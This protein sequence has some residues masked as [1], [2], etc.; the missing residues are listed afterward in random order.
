[1]KVLLI[2]PPGSDM[3]LNVGLGYLAASLQETGNEV[4]VLDLNNQ[5]TAGYW[6]AAIYRPSPQELRNI[7][8][9][10]IQRRFQPDLVG[11]SVK[12]FTSQV[13]ARI[14]LTVRALNPSIKIL[15]GGPHITL[16]GVDYVKETGADVGF[17][18]ESEYVIAQVCTA[19]ARQQE[20][21]DIK[22]IILNHGSETSITSPPAAIIDLDKLS[23]PDYRHFTSTKNNGGKIDDYFLLTSRGCPYSCTFCSVGQIMGKKWRKR[24]PQNVINELLMAHENY[25]IKHF[26]IIDDNFTLDMNRAKEICELIISSKINLNWGCPNGVFAARLD[27]E[28]VKLMKRAGCTRV[29]IGIESVDEKV[30]KSTKKRET[31]QDIENAIRMCHDVGIEVQGFF[32]IG[33]PCSTLQSDL[34]SVEF[35]KKNK[36]DGWWNMLTPYPGTEVLY[37]VNANATTLGD[38]QTGH[39][40]SQSHTPRVVFE[41]QDYTASERTQAFYM[42][43]LRMNH[44]GWLVSKE[45]IRLGK[46]LRLLYYSLRYAPLTFPSIVWFLITWIPRKIPRSLARTLFRRMDHCLA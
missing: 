14:I 18:G 46:I 12:S 41:T 30:L 11:I 9:E 24:S 7:V 26:N 23:F 6:G 17:I 5:S 13:S 2:D 4:C 43:H 39:Y 37:W 38:F 42:I 34:K 16:F 21:T 8:T 27:E 28:L 45:S 19:L 33:L 15:V 32:I 22:G 3:G 35:A 29:F 36:I 10:F 40:V 31:L 20:L 25:D 1:M 44:F